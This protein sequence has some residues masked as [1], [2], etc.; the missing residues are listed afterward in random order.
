MTERV[1]TLSWLGYLY[2]IDTEQLEASL[3]TLGL[4]VGGFIRS[5]AWY[6][7]LHCLLP[8]VTVTPSQIRR[9]IH[10]YIGM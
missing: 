6:R 3:R 5:S 10:C 8:A 1:T 2:L 4:V 7:R 9:Y